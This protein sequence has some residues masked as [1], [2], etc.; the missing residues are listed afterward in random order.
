MVG[1]PWHLLNI[2]MKVLTTISILLGSCDTPSNVKM[3]MIQPNAFMG[4]MVEGI[5]NG[6]DLSKHK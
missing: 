4:Y 1:S 6:L 2:L 3:I 5:T